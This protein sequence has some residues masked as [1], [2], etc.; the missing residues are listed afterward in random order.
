MASWAVKPKEP[1][2]TI[3]TTARKLAR[4]TPMARDALDQAQAVDH[5]GGAVVSGCHHHKE[6]PGPDRTKIPG[7][8][9]PAYPG[10]LTP[11]FWKV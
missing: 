7:S 2:I 8:R 11:V 9:H 5:L 4:P 6:V 1:N 10:E 3:A